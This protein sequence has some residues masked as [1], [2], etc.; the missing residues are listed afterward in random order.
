M[1]KRRT[2]RM[3]RTVMRKT[4]ES[5]WKLLEMWKWVSKMI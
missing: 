4:M 5:R 3:I 1:K 2:T